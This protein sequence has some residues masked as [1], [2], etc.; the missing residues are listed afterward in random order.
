M[1]QVKV[2]IPSGEMYHF[3][4]KIQG[5]MKAERNNSVYSLEKTILKI[6]KEFQEIKEGK[7]QF[8]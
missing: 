3:V 1:P 7:K 8:T 6:I 2:K 4:L 5:E